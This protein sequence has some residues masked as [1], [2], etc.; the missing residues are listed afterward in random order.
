MGEEA[1]ERKI[2]VKARLDIRRGTGRGKGWGFSGN[3]TPWAGNQLH[4]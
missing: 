3:V 1:R 4:V 2:G